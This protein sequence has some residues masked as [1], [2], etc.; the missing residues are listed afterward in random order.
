MFPKANQDI[1]YTEIAD[2][3]E[4]KIKCMAEETCEG[5]TWHKVNL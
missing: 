1:I 5:F 4:C 3:E 2:A